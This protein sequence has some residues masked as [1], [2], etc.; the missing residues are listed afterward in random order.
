[1]SSINCIS[2]VV[3]MLKP[4]DLVTVLTELREVAGSWYN[5]GLVLKLTSGTLDAMKGDY[6]HP[7]D[8]LRDMLKEWL[9]HSAHP[10]WKNLIDA[11]SHPL[12]GK[13]MLAKQLKATYCNQGRRESPEGILLD[14]DYNG[15]VYFI[16]F[17]T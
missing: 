13:M 8:C 9:C 11:L 1:M 16:R 17:V 2:P 14:I 4:G 6:K 15:R 3:G 10:S 5:I 12:I 7:K